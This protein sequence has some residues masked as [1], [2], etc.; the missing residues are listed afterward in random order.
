MDMSHALRA[1]LPDLWQAGKPQGK[2]IMSLLQFCGSD[3]CYT[4]L[5]LYP[6]CYILLFTS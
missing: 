2:S 4:L 3:D 1:C 6:C 5:Q